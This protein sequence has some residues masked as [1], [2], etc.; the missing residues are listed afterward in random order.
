MVRQGN[1]LGTGFKKN[2]VKNGDTMI[3]RTTGEALDPE[4][5]STCWQNKF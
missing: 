1:S 2:I 5:D 4:V 3:D